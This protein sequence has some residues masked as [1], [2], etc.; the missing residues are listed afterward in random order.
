[1]NATINLTGD[2]NS[3]FLQ[4]EMYRSNIKIIFKTEKNINIY[5]SLIK[6]FFT[7]NL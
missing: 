4:A 3:I 6:L 5:V 7:S 2:S 1:M